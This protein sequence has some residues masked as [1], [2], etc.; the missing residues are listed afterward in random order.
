MPTASQTTSP[1][2]PRVTPREESKVTAIYLPLRHVD[3]LRSIGGGSVSNG[4]RIIISRSIN[5][6]EHLEDEPLVD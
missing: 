6:S 2:R 3:H 5:E 1:K 4:A